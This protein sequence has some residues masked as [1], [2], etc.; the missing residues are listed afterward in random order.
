MTV[1]GFLVD[2]D[3]QRRTASGWEKVEGSL[4]AG[5]AAL[6]LDQRLCRAIE[7][8]A[9]S[10]CYA[11]AEAVHHSPPVVY[12][13]AFRRKSRIDLQYWLWYPYNDYSPTV[14]AG[15]LWQMHEGD[16]EAISVILDLD[17]NPLLAGYSQHRA[18]KRRAWA[19]V[20]KQGARPIVYVALGSHAN[21]FAPGEHR[22]DPRATEPLLIRVIESYGLKPID[23]AGTGATL[24]PHLIR[25]RAM[26]PAW[27]AFAG[28]WGE[29]A[30]VHFPGNAPLAAGL[31]PPGPA[32]HPQWR[33]PVVEVL[34]WPRG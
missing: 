26:S 25:V 22:L 34:S 6:R 32:F 17:G 11:T 30:Y 23:Y 33:R 28:A 7:G 3:L 19:N 21:F 29:D 8:P 5:G 20:R 12:G 31:G 10:P 27:M 14:P 2:S 24:R 15:D 4:P 13:A 18:G 1:D 9:A 16:W